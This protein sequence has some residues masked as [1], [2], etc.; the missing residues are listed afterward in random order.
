MLNF[1]VIKNSVVDF[2]LIPGPLIIIEV[3]NWKRLEERIVIAG[4]DT[5]YYAT[6]NT[7]SEGCS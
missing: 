3:F 7:E 6:E 2:A 1:E 5:A 4:N